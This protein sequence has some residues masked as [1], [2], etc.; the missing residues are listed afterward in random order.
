MFSV[1]YIVPSTICL[2]S[3]KNDCMLLCR[4]YSFSAL[5]EGGLFL[6]A[7][8]LYV[9]A[10]VVIVSNAHAQFTLLDAKLHSDL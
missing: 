7:T 2:C 6:S 10:E 8:N 3:T 1:L 9:V 4:N 5:R